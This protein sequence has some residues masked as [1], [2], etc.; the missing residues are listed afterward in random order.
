PRRP[1]ILVRELDV[2]AELG[3]EVERRMRV[4]D[5]DL[6]LFSHFDPA[7]ELGRPFR[8]EASARA[9]VEHT[10]PQRGVSRRLAGAVEA[11]VLLVV[12]TLELRAA[13]VKQGAQPRMIL[14]SGDAELQ[15]A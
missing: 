2:K 6:G 10:K 1:M 7:H 15:L 5:L 8:G 13:L 11:V 3:Q 14:R 4:L 12:L 9:A